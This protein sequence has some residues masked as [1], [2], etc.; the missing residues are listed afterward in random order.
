MQRQKI[1]IT[2]VRIEMFAPHRSNQSLQPTAGRRDDQ[3]EFMKHIIEVAKLAP[4][5]GG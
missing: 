5:S 3:F 4:A 1:I 2:F